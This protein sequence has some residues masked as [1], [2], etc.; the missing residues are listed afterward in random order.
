MEI[1]TML[2]KLALLTF[3]LIL[4]QFSSSQENYL[5]GKIV[6]FTG[7]TINGSIDYRNWERNPSEITF[8]STNG[9]II[10]YKPLEIVSF[11]VKD[12]IYVSAIIKTE[13]NSRNTDHLKLS[14]EIREQI[15]TAFLQ[16]MIQGEKSLYYYNN[17]YRIINFY[18][19]QNSDFEYLEYRKYKINKAGRKIIK[20]ENKYIGQL[21]YYLNDCPTIQ[22]KL[23]NVKYSKK[24]LE[25]LFQYYYNCKNS[26][27][28][29]QK[30]TEKVSVEGGILAGVSITNFDF[31]SEVDKVLNNTKYSSSPNFS[32]ALFMEIILQR[33]LRKWSLYNE[34][35]YTSYNL[36]GTYTEYTN[37]NDF[38]IT[39]T[40]LG[41]SYLKLINMIR[42]KYPFRRSFIFINAGITNGFAFNETNY[43]TE[44]MKYYTIARSQEG[45]VLEDFRKNEQGFLA[46]IGTKKNR[47]SIE[48][49]YEIGNGMSEYS[50]LKST[51]SR[52]YFL[53]GFR[54]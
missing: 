16:T 38:R 9:K 32:A 52:Y 19:K 12:E 25:R 22:T 35:M 8:K 21:T 47:Y 4:Y 13:I 51:T 7:D 46:G 48:F 24:S 1:N 53:L 27:V 43:K 45:V 15:D 31:E 10:N 36:D 33:N 14:S 49:R 37:E 20:E 26:D 23:K 42:F 28:K 50:L 39:Y 2:K 40:N 54:F 11:S 41:F 3:G 5:P 18:I 34:I 44:E 30:K 17:N 6:T 29:F